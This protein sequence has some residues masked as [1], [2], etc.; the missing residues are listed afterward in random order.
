MEKEDWISGL[1]APKLEYLEFREHCLSGSTMT[2]S[3][4]LGLAIMDIG[5]LYMF[6]TSCFEDE[7]ANL[8]QFDNLI[9]LKIGCCQNNIIPS[10]LQHSPHL[11][12]LIIDEF[13]SSN[14][15]F[16]WSLQ[17]RSPSV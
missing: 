1:Q 15:A 5:H 16:T 6:R 2:A 3:P 11:K 13:L 7:H 9:H 17:N 8:L 12:L 10:I 4:S 14:E